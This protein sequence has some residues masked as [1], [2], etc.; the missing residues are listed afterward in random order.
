[1]I[2]R[3]DNS[4]ERRPA[5]VLISQV[6]HA[7]LS[8]ALAADWRHADLPFAEQPEQRHELLAAIRHHDDGWKQ[9]ESQ[10]EIDPA[11]SMPY[12]FAELPRP[13]ALSIWNQSIAAAATIGPLAGGMVAGHFIWL[14]QHHNANEPVDAQWLDQTT[15]QRDQWL[16]EWIAADQTHTASLAEECIGWLRWFDLLSL[17]LCCRE[18]T[19]PRQVE[20]P[21][22]ARLHLAPR[23]LSEIISGGTSVVG[24]QFELDRWPFEHEEDEDRRAE[25]RVYT[26]HAES[27]AADRYADAEQL[28]AAGRAEVTLRWE[29]VPPVA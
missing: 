29:F 3:D 10:P 28:A 4:H 13:T 21:P 11:T 24:Q 1:M 6:A 16:A 19:K 14:H 15:Q 5:W 7:R 2:R 17:V 27:V 26:L 8:A 12:D 23:P 25:P 18:T 20:L 22:V 9:W